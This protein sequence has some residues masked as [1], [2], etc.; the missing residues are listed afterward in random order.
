MTLEEKISKIQEP[1]INGTTGIG[2]LPTDKAKT[3]GEFFNK[4]VKD[5]LPG[6]DVIKA[7]HR[8]LMEYTREENWD[9]LSCCVRFGNNGGKRISTWGE[10]GY[11]KLRRG[12]LTQNTYD[13]FEYFFADNAF[14]AFVY[15]MALDKFVPFDDEELRAVFYEHKFP[16]SFGFFID[17]KISEYRGVKIDK[18]LNPGFLGNYKLSHI[19]DAGEHFNV[20]GV[21]MGD[22]ILSEKF[23]PIGH[24]DDFLKESDKI[25]KM[26]I[27][28]T[29]KRVI[30]A[31][32]L[33]FAH[34]FNYFLT[35]TKKHH[36]CGQKV[37]KKDIGEDPQMIC[38][39]RWYLQ[40]EYPD[41]FKEYISRIM[42]YGDFC[43]SDKAGDQEIDI[44]YGLDV[45]SE[46]ISTST[47]EASKGVKVRS[48]KN[49][50]SSGNEFVDFEV[51]ARHN[52]VK[53]PSGYSSKIRAIMKELNIKSVLELD[54]SI[55]VAINFCDKKVK[56]LRK[57][58]NQK[59]AKKY[60]DYRSI[61]KKY[62]KYLDKC[63]NNIVSQ[64]GIDEAPN[65]KGAVAY[66]LYISYKK[67]WSSF[68]PMGE[69]I[70]GYRIDNDTIT[71]F[72]DVGFGSG[73]T[74]TKKIS[75]KDMEELFSI[76]DEAIK[77][78]AFETSNT[79][80]L[81]VHGHIGTYNY[82]YR[83]EADNDCGCLFT[84]DS[85]NIRYQ[86]LINQITK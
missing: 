33:R 59:V 81:T 86:N 69:H 79:S 38:Y 77:I 64:V 84:D 51:F 48:L 35:P 19:F 85:L 12:W 62:K 41:E 17:N 14:P 74:K 68:R 40:K 25:R 44:A 37:Y 39:M 55:D 50:F 32:F 3:I 61:L 4:F 49:S 1:S 43:G 29:S 9:K 72:Y 7:W 10:K 21:E 70:S 34:P 31:K 5:R 78:N 16:Y 15:K 82:R 23:Y 56:E 8:V 76:L 42:W 83:G 27:D 65:E 52:G 20:D 2:L 54:K 26:E 47:G 75:P 73:K 36:V 57:A 80:I 46:S 71:V 53:N 22:A 60:S 30:V 58:A 18:G 28:E 45:D 6:P 67:G 13:E 63:S 66:N 24:S 11:Y